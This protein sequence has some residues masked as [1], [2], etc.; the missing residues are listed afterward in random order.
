MITA[1]S[2]L[3]PDGATT[4]APLAFLAR[5]YSL[6]GCEYSDAIDNCAPNGGQPENGRIG[7]TTGKSS[8][9]HGICGMFGS[10]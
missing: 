8:R 1:G 6:G 2:A 10:K 5:L 3:A 9:D 7:P 4:S